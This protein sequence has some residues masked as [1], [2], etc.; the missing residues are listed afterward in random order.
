MDLDPSEPDNPWL[1]FHRDLFNNGISPNYHR[2]SLERVRVAQT[3]LGMEQHPEL[4]FK[5]YRQ[6]IA[7][8]PT[9]TRRLDGDQFEY[10]MRTVEKMA[11]E[12]DAAEKKE[13]AKLQKEREKKD[14]KDKEKKEKEDKKKKGQE[15][16]TGVTQDDSGVVLDEEEDEEEEREPEPV[17]AP[18]VTS[19]DLFY[20]RV[21]VRYMPEVMVWLGHGPKA[22]QEVKISDAQTRLY[23]A[24]SLQNSS[25]L[26]HMR[27]ECI[28]MVQILWGELPREPNTVTYEMYIRVLQDRERKRKQE[29]EVKKDEEAIQKRKEREEEE[30]AKTCVGRGRRRRRRP[31]RKWKMT[32]KNFEEE[33]L[34]QRGIL[35]VADV[36]SH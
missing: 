6:F 21:L 31:A 35:L 12:E 27:F 15:Q 23:G 25:Q 22:W 33:G 9:I 29:E 17:P 34:F 11:D 30:K 10:A 7:N 1:L 32:P 14:K 36:P 3:M 19:R 2:F 13:Q 16:K 8:A 4:E 28:R 24:I 5:D 20:D 18:V 26:S